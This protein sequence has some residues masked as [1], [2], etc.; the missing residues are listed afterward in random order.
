MTWQKFVALFNT[1]ALALGAIG[2]LVLTMIAA[3]AIFAF[4]MMHKDTKKLPKA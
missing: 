3:V 2:G 4:L 1:D